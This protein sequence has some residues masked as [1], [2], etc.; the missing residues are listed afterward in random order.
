MIQTK[1]NRNSNR[2]LPKDWHFY[3]KLIFSTVNLVKPRKS[4]DFLLQ[5]F[6]KRPSSNIGFFKNIMLYT[7]RLFVPFS[8]ADSLP[9]TWES[10]SMI[11]TSSDDKA[12]RTCWY[13]KAAAI[14]PNIGPTQNTQWC[15]QWPTTIDGP[16]DRAGFK[17]APVNGPWMKKI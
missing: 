4:V 14:A 11:S 15:S 9:F 5:T 13:N 3:H 6:D 1:S 12:R 2:F 7:G 10:I 8:F 16:K 17:L